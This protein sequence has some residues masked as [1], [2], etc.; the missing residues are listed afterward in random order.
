MTRVQFKLDPTL[1][2]RYLSPGEDQSNDLDGLFYGPNRSFTR[3]SI[4]D[5]SDIIVEFSLLG[6]DFQA[7]HHHQNSF[8]G[9]LGRDNTRITRLF[10]RKPGNLLF[11]SSIGFAQTLSGIRKEARAIPVLEGEFPA[12]DTFRGLAQPL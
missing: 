12:V 10:V 5:D 8:L 6:G 7:I 9:R 11:C 1:Y 4:F 3:G 2:Y